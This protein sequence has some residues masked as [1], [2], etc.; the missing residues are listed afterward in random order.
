[1]KT[2]NSLRNLL[3]SFI[4]QFLG[5]LITFISRKIFINSLGGNYLGIDGLFANI[6]TLLSLVELGIGP[7]MSYALY[8]PISKNDTEKIKSLMNL[9]KNAYRIIG[10]IV[11][12]IGFC[13]LPIYRYLINDVP[14][15]NNLDLIFILFVLNTAFSYFY[16]YKRSLIICNEKKY[17]TTA[18]N[19]IY[20]EIIKLSVEL[21]IIPPIL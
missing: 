21:T 1:M 12:F 5:I 8:Y 3:V 17:I 2:K 19:P 20:F 16:S 7:A 9:Y 10:I 14:N 4:G 18:I 11:L 6:I 15:I 13:L